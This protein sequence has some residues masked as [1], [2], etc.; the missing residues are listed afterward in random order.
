MQPTSQERGF[1]LVELLVVIA[2]IAILAALL[3]PA[4]ESALERARRAKC[5][6]NLKQIGTAKEMYLNVHGVE[7]PW[8]SALYPEFVDNMEL[9]ICPSDPHEGKE[10]GKPPWDCYHTTTHTP[11]YSG[12]FRETEDLNR[13]KTGMDNWTYTVPGWNNYPPFSITRPGYTIRF[14]SLRNVRPYKLRNDL[15]D[16]CSYIYEF[17]AAQCYWADD[18]NPD[19]PVLGGNGDGVV[20][21]AEQKY[22]TEVKGYGKT[23]SYGDCVPVARCFWHTTEELTPTDYV[24]NLARHHGVYLSSPTGTGWMEHCKPM[25]AATP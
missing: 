1:T 20:S 14:A 25:P 15:V 3:M 2:I 6:S 10:G 18:L 9:Y 11:D 13:N 23:E 5:M 21:W 24:I 16:A 4:L 8:F 7:T 17:C 19:R 22:T 12:Q